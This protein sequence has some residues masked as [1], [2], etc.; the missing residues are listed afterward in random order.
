MYQSA[1][2]I[3][4]TK[5]SEL[6]GTVKVCLKG[7]TRTAVARIAGSFKPRASCGTADAKT[8]TCTASD[9]CWVGSGSALIRIALPWPLREC[10]PMLSWMFRKLPRLS[11][12]ALT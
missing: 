9:G 5:E 3:S 2:R 7:T 1:G 4:E 11:T 6:L 12:E 10:S 8:S